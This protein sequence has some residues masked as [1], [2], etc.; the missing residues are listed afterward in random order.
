MLK[1]SPLKINKIFKIDEVDYNFRLVLLPKGTI[2]YKGI[3][4]YQKVE[5][6]GTRTEVDSDPDTYMKWVKDT[7]RKRV[8]QWFAPEKRVA[9]LFAQS[10]S[11]RTGKSSHL[12]EL[13]TTK[14]LKLLFMVRENIEN[15]QKLRIQNLSKTFMI[16]DRGMIDNGGI[17]RRSTHISKDRIFS[18]D[19]TQK[20]EDIDGY[21]APRLCNMDGTFETHAEFMLNDISHLVKVDEYDFSPT[22]RKR[23]DEDED[24]TPNK[25]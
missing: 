2:I 4:A 3:G 17:L 21:Y 25:R 16:D 11:N 6:F 24:S 22:K 5:M 15:L 13:K 20:I 10:Y 9:Q 19:L 7:E 18:V 14:D 1:K 8:V 23:E 12:L